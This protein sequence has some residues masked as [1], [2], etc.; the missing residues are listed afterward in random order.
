MIE[1]I[2]PDQIRAIS[3]IAIT[4]VQG[5]VSGCEQCSQTK[6]STLQANNSIFSKSKNQYKQEKANNA[7]IP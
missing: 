3:D 5:R 4:I 2:S 7:S 6:T 1:F